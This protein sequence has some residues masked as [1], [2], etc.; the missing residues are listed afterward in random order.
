MSE[1]RMLSEDEVFEMISY[2]VAS[3]QGLLDEPAAYGSL[4]LIDAAGR[5]A[6]FAMNGASEETESF[7]EELR[8]EIDEGK[9]L[10]MSNPDAYAAFLDGSVRK[11]ARELKRRRVGLT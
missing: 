2:L 4:R 5:L 9:L 11:I 10:V 7:L 8:A 1:K 6:G 3:A